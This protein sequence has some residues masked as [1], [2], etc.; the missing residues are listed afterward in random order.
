MT[1]IDTDVIIEIM[2]GE[3]KLLA[4]LSGFGQ[5]ALSVISAMELVF[6]AR[7]Q[8]EVRRIERA[9]SSLSLYCACFRGPNS[10]LFSSCCVPPQQR[11]VIFGGESE[12]LLGFII[13]KL[14]LGDVRQN[15]KHF[16][17]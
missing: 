15:E 7:N 3:N 8:Q 10:Y 6:G 4:T 12:N 9:L 13:K 1:L 14:P 16:T 5:C 2:K 11:H 17:L